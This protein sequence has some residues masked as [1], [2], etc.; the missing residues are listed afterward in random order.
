MADSMGEHQALFRKALASVMLRRVN[1][2]AS[3]QCRRIQDHG[4]RR[5]DFDFGIIDSSTCLAL[6]T[7][8]RAIS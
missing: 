3:R 6:M 2:T 8:S 1:R 7:D 4:D 5:S